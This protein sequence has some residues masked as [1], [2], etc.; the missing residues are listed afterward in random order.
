MIMSRQRKRED[1]DSDM[2]GLDTDTEGDSDS[3]PPSAKRAKQAAKPSVGK[4]YKAKYR[5]AWRSR[6][7]CITPTRDKPHAFHCTTCRKDVSCAHQGERDV[8]RHISSAQHQRNA[9]SLQHTAKIGQAFSASTSFLN[10]VRFFV[11]V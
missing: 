9:S 10:K 3:T 11:F 4:K 7:P 6:W 5:L 8:T 1:A 2:T